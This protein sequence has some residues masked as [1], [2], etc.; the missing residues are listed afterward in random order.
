MNKIFTPLFRFFDSAIAAVLHVIDR[1]GFSGKQK[2]LFFRE[3]AYL[4]K[5]GIS[6]MAAVELIIQS[7]D[8]MAVKTLA[9]SL[10]TF[11]NE[12]KSLSYAFNR[13]P[14]YFDQG[15]FS[16]VKAG[17]MSGTLPSVLSSLAEEYTYID[18]VK[19]KYIGAM[20]YPTMLMFVAVISV[21]SLFVFV[22]PG[23]FSIADSFQ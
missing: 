8:N 9:S 2:I 11:L 1:D 14:E 23:I 6:V 22:L 17:E 10:Y 21:I 19:N 12:G 7:S 4:L 5:G 3:L 18:E 20:M 16:I 13:L 15:D